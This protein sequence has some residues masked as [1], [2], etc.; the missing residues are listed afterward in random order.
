MSYKLV[1]NL[2]CLSQE[3]YSFLIGRLP[4]DCNAVRY[5]MYL[6]LAKW[7]AMS[8]HLELCKCCELCELCKLCKC[9]YYESVILQVLKC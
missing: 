8:V 3:N 2:Q 6:L 7:L 9:P 1:T 4:Y 5:V